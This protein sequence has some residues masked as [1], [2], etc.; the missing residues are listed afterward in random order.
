MAFSQTMKFDDALDYIRNPY[1]AEEIFQR[2]QRTLC[3]QL[4]DS[5]KNVTQQK[6]REFFEYSKLLNLVTIAILDEKEST[7][8]DDALSVFDLVFT[9]SNARSKAAVKVPDVEEAVLGI[10][11]SVEGN[12]HSSIMLVQLL[13]QRAYLNVDTGLLSES[14]AYAA[15]QGGPEFQTWLSRRN[16][17]L[18][19]DNVTPTVLSRR[20]DSELR[21]SLNRPDRAN[22]FSS[23]MRDELVE[24]LRMAAA[25]RS[26]NRILLEG[27]G[28][29][30]CTG[31][32]LN[33]FGSL[34]ST[35]DAHLIRMVNNPAFWMSKL[36]DRMSVHLHGKCI[37]AGIELPAFC[38]KVIADRTV[39]I[40]LP[41]IKMGLIP[42]AGGTVSIPRRIGPQKTAYLAL[43]GQ[44]IDSQTAL[45]W[46]LVNEI[47]PKL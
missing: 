21:I 20:N 6:T 11:N 28:N 29:S 38:D 14:I 43:S 17:T 32:D 12:P 2:Q 8:S 7:V 3:I 42:G 27:K 44:S 15:L 26:I 30:F 45:D 41:E 31:G 34:D 19:R 40:S 37:G 22:A 1:V 46:E 35:S 25:D 18:G 36:H 10:K 39:S 4:A 24:Q 33:E 9:S 16:N 47:V 23:A 13:R 5:C